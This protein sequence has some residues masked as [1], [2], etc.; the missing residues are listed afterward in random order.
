[1]WGW[2]D[3]PYDAG[4]IVVFVDVAGAVTAVE[5]RTG[6]I[7]WT[8]AM[9]GANVLANTDD[10]V[11]VSTPA[12]IS[13]VNRE[14]GET[15]WTNATR[16]DDE[17]A[18]AGEHPAALDRDNLIIPSGAATVAIEARTGEEVWRGATLGNPS[19]A[20]A[21]VVGTTGA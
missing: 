14:T 6:E 1:M 19:A 20:D 12:G 7:R 11:I 18:Y 16:V 5:A 13:G 17:I 4:G 15:A 3:G 2:P 8:S 21:V 10:L 9:P